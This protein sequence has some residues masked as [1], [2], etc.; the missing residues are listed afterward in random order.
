MIS[1]AKALRVPLLTS[2]YGEDA[3]RLPRESDKW[4]KRYG[5]LFA[6][7]T[8]F[9]VEGHHMGKQLVELGCPDSKILVQHL[10]VE[11]DK[12]PYRTRQRTAGEPLRVLVAGRFTEKKGILYAI[13]A[14]AE[15]VS[16]G[17]AAVMTVFGDSDEAKAENVRT[18][19]QILDAISRNGLEDLIYLRGMRPLEELRAAYYEHHVLLSPSVQAE[20]GDNEGGA[21]VTLIEA[22]ATGMPVISSHHCDIPEIV[23]SGTT[24]LL[25]NEKDVGQLAE[26]LRVLYK[27]P[28]MIEKLGR[29]ARQHVVEQYD[30][31]K[32]GRKLEQIYHR[33][34]SI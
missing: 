4:T 25:A 12:F 11:L 22:G 15:L 21:P 30:A 28:G 33:A 19:R 5:R 3:S 9:L 27:Q 17:V 10:G 16:G 14:F 24:G 32:Q 2:F 26:Y 7:G 1:L 8:Y 34:L 6:V 23:R 13:Q 20:N 29:N 18:K 31:A